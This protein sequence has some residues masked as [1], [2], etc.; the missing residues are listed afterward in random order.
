M[1]VFRGAHDRLELKRLRRFLDS[2]FEKVAHVTT[3]VSRRAVALVERHAL[4]HRIAIGDALI[5]ATA[6]TLNASVAT[7]NVR[8]YDY[9]SGLNVLALRNSAPI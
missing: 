3:E 8:H 2:E 7:A 9:I 5:A 1:E 6:L 4:S